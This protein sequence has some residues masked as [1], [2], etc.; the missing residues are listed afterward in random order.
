ME[1]LANPHLTNRTSCIGKRIDPRRC[2]NF[3]LGSQT[4]TIPELLVETVS[5]RPQ[6]GPNPSKTKDQ[7]SATDGGA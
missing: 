1:E 3:L 4:E 7:A 2:G 5:D 6:V